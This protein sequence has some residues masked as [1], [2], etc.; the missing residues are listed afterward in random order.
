MTSFFSI[1]KELL[2]ITH[3][4]PL[5]IW[6]TSTRVE[7]GW[8][9]PHDAFFQKSIKN[10]WRQ[11]KYYMK[12]GHNVWKQQHNFP[13]RGY[14]SKSEKWLRQQEIS[15]KPPTNPIR[16]ENFCEIARKCVKL[17]FRWWKALNKG[18]FRTL[19][20]IYGAFLGK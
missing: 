3:W 11:Q 20:H 1:L 6:K 9:M 19:S 10:Y 2:N 17:N 7:W 12:S 16:H 8:I 14:S 4:W 15:Y 5:N 13:M 18:L